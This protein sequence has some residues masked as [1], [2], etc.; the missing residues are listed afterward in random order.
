MIMNKRSLIVVLAM[1]GLT[2][3]QTQQSYT[4]VAQAS[5][6]EGQWVDQNGILSTFNNGKFQTKTTDGTNTLLAI[7]NYKQVTPTLAEIELKSLVRRTV[8]QVNCALATQN[9]MNCTT[10]SGAQFALLRQA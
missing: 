4:P 1:L 6:F 5:S 10:S 7:G 3:C 9:R 2:A 8:T